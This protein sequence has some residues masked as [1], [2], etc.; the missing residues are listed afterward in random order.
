MPRPTRIFAGMQHGHLTVVREIEQRKNGR[1]FFE[2]RCE[3]G[4]TVAIR[5]SH[6]YPERQHCSQQCSFLASKRVVDLT[7]QRFERWLVLSPAGICDTTGWARWNCKCDCGTERIV[8]GA[9]LTAKLSRSCGCLGKDI[10]RKGRTLEELVE[11]RRTRSREANR[12]NPARVKAA[13]IRY[14]YR[15]TRATPEWLTD[16]Q[17]AEMNAVYFQAR[18]LTRRTGVRH[19]VDH[20]VPLKGKSVSGLHVPWNLQILTQ[21]ENVTKS[22]RYAELLG[23]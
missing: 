12:N 11:L 2:C 6:F 14:E 9:Q 20:I 4:K 21:Q 15:L 16:E 7:G 10:Q 13:K 19:Q 22:N 3:C 5:S 18:R 8:A 17:W 23:D 1:K